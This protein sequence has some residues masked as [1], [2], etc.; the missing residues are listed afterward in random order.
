MEFSLQNKGTWFFFDEEDETKGGVCLRIITPAEVEKIERIC[1][2][3]RDVIK[4]GVHY[5]KV[6]TD[7]KQYSRLLWDYCIIDWKEVNVDGNPLECTTENKTKLITGDPGFS[8]FI[9][10]KMEKLQDTLD[11]GSLLK[12]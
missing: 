6:D 11:T 9:I 1:T 3:K 2:K 7:E 4:K 12:N 8:T 5:E 10:K